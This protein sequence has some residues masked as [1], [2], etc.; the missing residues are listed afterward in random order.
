MPHLVLWCSRKN[1]VFLFGVSF[2]LTVRIAEY[3]HPIRMTCPIQPEPSFLAALKIEESPRN[4]LFL[5][6]LQSEQ[7]FYWVLLTS[8]SSIIPLWG[9][10]SSLWTPC[11]Y[12]SPPRNPSRK[13]I[14]WYTIVPNFFPS[15]ETS[16]YTSVYPL[17]HAAIKNLHIKP[18]DVF[19]LLHHL[20]FPSTFNEGI[21]TN[22]TPT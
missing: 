17:L 10:P 3:F 4:T 12:S 21:T 20:Y 13:K 7:T 5:R 9:E 2:N 15:Y 11:I 16:Q 22:V 14:R 1:L 8:S 19:F 6:N 18:N